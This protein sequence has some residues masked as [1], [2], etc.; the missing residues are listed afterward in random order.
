M[1]REKERVREQDNSKN[2]CANKAQAQL[3]EVHNNN[4]IFYNRTQCGME[5]RE[6]EEERGG[7]RGTVTK[8]AQKPK[9]NRQNSD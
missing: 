7:E 5:E 8:R 1:E 4:I 2:M 9:K 3:L 6:R